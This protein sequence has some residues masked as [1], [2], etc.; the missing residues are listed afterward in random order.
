MKKITIQALARDIANAIRLEATKVLDF[1]NG[2]IRVLFVPQCEDANSFLGGFGIDCKIDLGY[3][4]KEGASCTRPARDDHK[5]F[6]CYGYAAEKIDGCAYA[7]QN[8]LGRRSCDIP[9]SAETWGRVNDK[10]CVVYDILMTKRFGIADTS[11]PISYL[12]VYIAVSGATSREDELCALAAGGV[13][14]KWCDE[15]S[16]DDGFGHNEKYLALIRPDLNQTVLK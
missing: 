14:Q 16:D 8:G 7:L 5:E 13:L 10:G 12:R 2:A 9:E 6:A 15:E 1:D 11:P 4:I 3:A